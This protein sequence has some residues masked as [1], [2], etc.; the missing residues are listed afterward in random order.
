MTHIASQPQRPGRQTSAAAGGVAPPL[1]LETVRPD[2]IPVE[3]Y[4]LFFLNKEQCEDTNR[5]EQARCN[6]DVVALHG[7]NGDAFNTWTHSNGQLWLRDFLPSE[8][9]GARIF[10]F[11]YPS[12]VAF[13]LN[14]GKLDDFARSLL[15]KLSAVRHRPEQARP[16]IFICHSMGGIVV[17]RALILAVLD[18]PE[19]DSI[20]S[21]V[22]GI[23]FL[24][25]PHHG[26]GA[27][28]YP[29][30]LANVVNV[31]LAGSSGFVGRIRTDLIKSLEKDSKVLKSISTNFRNRA[32]K[33]KIVSFVEQKTTPPPQGTTDINIP[34]VPAESVF[35]SEEEEECLRSLSFKEIEFRRQTVESALGK[36]CDWL[37]SHPTYQS[38]DNT[39]S[40][41]QHNDLLWIEGKPG[42]GKST[43]MKEAFMRK[44]KSRTR[45]SHVMV[46]AFFFN[47]RGGFLE[48][49]MVGMFRSLLNQLSEQ[50][51]AVLTALLPT[52]RQKRDLH[53]PGWTWQ[54]EE[55]QEHV[56]ADFFTNATISAKSS[57]C[58]LRVCLSSRHYPNIQ[59]HNWS[60][61]RMEDCNTKDISTYVVAKL[62]TRINSDITVQ[63]LS[64]SITA[65]ALGV[66]LWVVLVVRQLVQALVDEETDDKL[67]AIVSSVPQGL[68]DVFKQIVDS[69]SQDERRE[70]AKIM[71]WV[72]LAQ[73]P[74]T[75]TELRYGLAF[76]TAHKTQKDCEASP[77][78]VKK[79]E[80][81][82]KLLRKRSRGLAGILKSGSGGP[83][84]VRFIHESAGIQNDS[85]HVVWLDNLFTSARLLSTLR[86][87][88]FGAAGTVRTTRTK[89]EYLAET[90]PNI[91]Q[92]QQSQQQPQ[93]RSQQQSREKDRGLDPSLLE[94]KN[95]FSGQIPWGKLYGC[96]SKDGK[97]L[98]FARKDQNVVLFVSTVSQ[99]D[100]FIKRLR[101]RPPITATNARTTRA[102]FSD[103][104]LKEL[105]I[106]EFINLYNHFMNGVNKAD[107]LRIYY[108][109]QRVHLKSWK[110]LW[111]WLLD[112]AIVNS[113][114]LSY[115][116][117]H[118]PDLPCERYT[119]QRKFRQDLA[120][121]LFKRSE[122]LT[123]SHYDSSV[124]LVDLVYPAEDDEEHI[125]YEKGKLNHCKACEAA[126]RKHSVAWKIAG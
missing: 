100:R 77:A 43:L 76:G 48:K 125:K 34:A 80:Q 73:R 44:L 74:L 32:S 126:G 21:A 124:P 10:S 1:L 110:P 98:E 88:G 117:R 50:V 115:Y 5:N 68:S 97:V 71:F 46:V 7:I 19:Y 120:I 85:R 45:I 42:A 41:T 20:R 83:A 108:N 93:Q 58:K 106:P 65:K 118:D 13:T 119:K 39:D 107:Q 79:D 121:E 75:A 64:E 47:A 11:G 4:G 109:T 28:Q 33:F 54:L 26:S 82:E 2:N 12:E 49:S 37:F 103:Q 92:S 24:G 104:V 123:T 14:T 29:Q 59:L 67:F 3:E 99:G 60:E 69:I 23:L 91:Q 87:Q 30:V 9:P 63:L 94:L 122:R 102:I 17:K 35:Y 25:T 36:T 53:Q 78:F 114:K 61:I 18:A 22:T 96:L 101:E 56:L 51:R 8:F 57:N 72:L 90:A 111:H 66:F 95:N 113:Y 27:T 16:I 52:Y 6:T 31:A 84:T 40:S 105:E 70:F 112:V 38:W 55:L 62:G 86:E 89:A 15:V 116:A 81:M